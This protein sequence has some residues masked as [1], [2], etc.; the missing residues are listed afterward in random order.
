MYTMDGMV[1]LCRKQ[2]RSTTT[3]FYLENKQ[4]KMYGRYDMVF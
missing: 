3:F 2:F 1:W 4:I